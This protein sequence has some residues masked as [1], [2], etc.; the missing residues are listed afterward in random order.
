MFDLH[1]N[2]C[3]IQPV[4]LRRLGFY[5]FI[6][7]QRQ[8]LTDREP[9]FIRLDGIHQTVGAGVV[10]F[11]DGVGDRRSGGPAIHGIIVRRGLDDLDLTGDGRILPLDFCGFAGLYI[12][13]LFL[14]VGNISLIFQFT[15]IV[16]A[17]GQIFK[18]DIPSVIAGFLRDGIVAGI[19]QNE[20]N[21]VDALAGGRIDLVDQDT[22]DGFVGHRFGRG[23]TILHSEIDGGIVKLEALAR[24][25]FHGIVAAA[26]QRHIHAAV[27][28]GGDGV[29]QTA[30]ADTADLEGGVGDTL[31]FVRRIHFHQLQPTDG[32]IIKIEGLRVIGVDHH[33]LRARILVDGVTGDGFF[34]RYHQCAGDALEDDL[35]VLVRVIQTVGADFSV[36]VGDKLAG[37]RSDLEGNALQ[38]RLAVQRGQ[39]VDDERAL[40]L[41]PE[42]HALGRLA[43]VDLDALRCPVQ[44]ESIHRFDL[45]CGNSHAVG[46]TLND[47][48]ACSVGGIVAVVGANY[49]TGGVCHKELYPGQR[50]I[51]RAGNVFLEN[52]CCSGFVVKGQ[53]LRIVGIDY[54]GLCAGRFING[55]ARNRLG[56]R[57]YHGADD[58]GD[59]DLTRFIGVINAV[60][61]QFAVGVGNEAA[62]RV[63]DL[64]LDA[65]QRLPV[66]AGADLADDEITGRLVQKLQMRRFAALDERVLG[67]V[68][69]Q[70]ARFC[71]DFTGNDRHAGFQ[72]IHQN[73]ACGIG[74]E[75]AVVVAEIMAA[76]VGQQ[77][78]Y[79]G[80]RFVL[81]VVAQLCNEQT[82]QRGIAEAERHHILILA[83]NPH[84]L[85]FAVDDVISIALNLL[86]DVS[87]AFEV[88][89]GERSVGAGHISP[90]DCAASAAG[91]AAKITQFKAAALQS[92]SGFGVIFVHDEGAVRN[93]V[94]GHGLR[95]IGFQI[96]LGDPAALNAEALGSGLLHQFVPATVYIGDGDFTVGGRCEHTEVV[97][98]AGGGIIRAVIDMEFGIGER[99]TGDAVSL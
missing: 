29:H 53:R 93:I 44:H 62:I 71:S 16:A 98:L 8:R 56:F 92:F 24:L 48:L 35:P 38:R 67:A 41:I 89:Y 70:V 46:Q 74:G 51:F 77:E 39:L 50:L 59:A 27:R 65:L 31:G 21:A 90:D 80:E 52:Q 19:V 99:I 47:D 68:I 30:I 54:H 95:G 22:G 14:R 60:A 10:N 2:G 84:R 9:V 94:H 42:G 36:F 34:L 7:R 88:C 61:G 26:F 87:A 1:L 63:G 66:G 75:A 81:A 32:S 96:E 20:G 40:S 4:K 91:I 12:H 69:Q 25:G 83:G 13:G 64:K 55:E 17:S 45:F 11:K 18:T 49:R 76:A 86:A 6:S 78:L 72:T 3:L 58:A 43:L 85:G 5:D 79:A 57:C 97:D 15:Q 33:G 82:S 73:F 23:S 37:S 28:S